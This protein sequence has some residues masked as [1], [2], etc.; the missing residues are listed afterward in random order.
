M[1]LSAHRFHHLQRGKSRCE[2]A[3]VP[4]VQ[5]W[6]YSNMPA[7]RGAVLDQISVPAAPLA[8]ETNQRRQL[9]LDPPDRGGSLSESRLRACATPTCRSV[10]AGRSG[11]DLA[12]S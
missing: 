6:L 11:A 2:G 5:P 1:S 3:P 10:S 9:H 7:I 8:V 12:Q 4:A